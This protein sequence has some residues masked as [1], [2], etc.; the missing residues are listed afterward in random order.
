MLF[1]G[2]A[3]GAFL[4]CDRRVG[5]GGGLG[6]GFLLA[7]AAATG[8]G[9]AVAGGRGGV[10]GDRSVCRFAHNDGNSLMFV[11]CDSTQSECQC[12]RDM[13]SPLGVGK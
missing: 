7:L 8:G 11:R 9:F 5:G 4:A 13:P 10:H 2:L 3:F 1:S 6:L 12:A